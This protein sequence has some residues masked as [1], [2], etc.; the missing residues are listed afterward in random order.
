MQQKNIER[1]YQN[2]P[3]TKIPWNSN[4]PSKHIIDLVE[5]KIITPCKT[6]DLGCGTGTNALY[7]ASKGFDVTGVDYSPTAIRIAK[8]TALKKQ[9]RCTFF[10]TDI[11]Y[12][13][14]ILP[15]TFTFAY[16][17]AVLHHIGPQQRKKYVQKVHN[18]LTTNGLYLSVCF[19]TKDPH[20][21]GTKKYRNTSLGTRLYF[22]SEHE[23]RQLFKP[24]FTIQ[25]LK[26]INIPGI[27]TPH[28]THYILM[29]KKK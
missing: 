2:I 22:S 29:H 13:V 20:F 9:I 5:N 8:K 19:S 1:I 15:E 18:L 7:L 21:G 24:Y 27:P 14:S 12:D 17:W 10:V 23:L 4:K 28:I 11:I 26:T 16:D 6:I 3:V 25:E